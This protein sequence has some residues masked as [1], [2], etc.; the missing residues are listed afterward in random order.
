MLETHARYHSRE[1]R[2]ARLGGFRD[3]KIGEPGREFLPDLQVL[4]SVTIKLVG[5][6]FLRFE[7]LHKMVQGMV[8]KDRTNF[9]RSHIGFRCV[10]WGQILKLTVPDSHRRRHAPN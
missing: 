4:A 8:S 10:R 6:L 1:R 5:R 9:I 3:R 7:M 2:R